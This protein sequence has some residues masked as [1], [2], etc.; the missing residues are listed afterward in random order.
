MIRVGLDCYGFIPFTDDEYNIINGQLNHALHAVEG[1][2][3][4]FM[5]VEG[6]S[7]A[8]INLKIFPAVPGAVDNPYLPTPFLRHDVHATIT[9]SHVDL[10]ESK[11]WS[12][13]YNL[14]SCVFNRADSVGISILTP[15]STAL[16]IQYSRFER[17]MT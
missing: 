12:Y 10:T 3:F 6:A 2:L 8:L 7:R 15:R 13:P 16:P 11:N 17:S 14:P 9:S 5:L 1:F 4:F